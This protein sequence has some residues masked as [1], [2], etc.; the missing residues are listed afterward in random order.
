MTTKD[1][2]E[3]AWKA[4][5]PDDKPPLLECFEA[6]YQ[7]PQTLKDACKSQ[8]SSTQHNIEMLQN[9][10]HQQEFISTFLWDLLHS[11][12]PL[13][14][15]LDSHIPVPDHNEPAYH[16]YNTVPG[17]HGGGNPDT[18]TP[19]IPQAP[20]KTILNTPSS[21]GQ[22]GISSNRW[23]QSQ[24]VE[25]DNE[26]C[27]PIEVTCVTHSAVSTVDGGSDP[28]DGGSTM[29]QKYPGSSKAEQDKV[30]DTSI[31]T[32]G[33]KAASDLTHHSQI[34]AIT[35][36]G[37][38]SCS[39]DNSPRLDHKVSKDSTEGENATAGKKLHRTSSD[40][41][42]NVD[43][44]DGK[45]KPVPAPRPSVHGPSFKIKSNMGDPG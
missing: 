17:G 7:S 21:Q 2:F 8:H 45:P 9:E 4:R 33:D 22:S 3:V 23:S 18:G 37:H 29:G 11:S 31:H 12:T 35:D 38:K 1:E 34:Q 26:L 42:T 24:S 44:D 28:I 19:S 13:S 36:T 10:L 41:N 32:Q 16:G 30:T 39:L 5:F 40:P 6:R 15:N 43:T 27:K 25:R 20:G 14:P